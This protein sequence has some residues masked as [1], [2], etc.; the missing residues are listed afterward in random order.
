MK[1]RRRWICILLMLVLL[2]VLACPVLAEEPEVIPPEFEVTVG[3]GGEAG[4]Y[5]VG[6]KVMFEVTISLPED[7]DSYKSYVLTLYALMP[8]GIAYYDIENKEVISEPEHVLVKDGIEFYRPEYGSSTIAYFTGETEVRF[9]HTDLKFF[10][11]GSKAVIKEVTG[12]MQLRFRIYCTV[13]QATEL[14]GEGHDCRFYLTYT[15]DKEWMSG[16]HPAHGEESGSSPVSTTEEKHIPIFTGELNVQLTDEKKGTPLPG[17]KFLLKNS[18]G[19]YF[20]DLIGWVESPLTASSFVAD[21]NGMLKISGIGDGQ[22]FLEPTE[23]PK[24]YVMPE[25]PIAFQMSADADKT[26]IHSVTVTM[27]EAKTESDPNAGETALVITNKKEFPT[28]AVIGISAAVLALVAVG[29]GVIIK[30]RK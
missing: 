19:L 8:K 21:E 4:V 15:N 23:V 11:Q 2:T 22:F 7:Y 20:S 14:G 10:E 6:D 5:S 3:D 12:D 9:W 13:A 26:G 30:R 25:E 28:G 17:G 1:E 24:G 27:G 29:L 16:L 18:E